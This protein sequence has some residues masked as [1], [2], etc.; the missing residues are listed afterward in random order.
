VTLENEQMAV[1]VLPDKGA[2]IYALR[3]KPQDIDVL[4]KAPWPVKMPGTGIPVASDSEAFWL[5]HYPGGWQE[6][7]PNV[8]DACTYRGVELGFHG[9]ASIL[10]WTYEVMERTL[11]RVAIRFSVDL[12]HSPFALTR[13]M[14]LTQ[15]EAVL[16]LSEEVVNKAP[17]DMDLMWGHHPAYGAPFLSEACVID[18]AADTM[19]ADGTYDPPGNYLAPGNV[20]RW[21]EGRDSQGR[22][23]DLSRIPGPHE[24]VSCFAYL[25]H[26]REGWIAITNTQLGFGVGMVWPKEIFPYVHLWQE[27][28]GSTVYPFYGRAYTVGIEPMSSIPGRGLAA[29]ME[30]TGT[31][32]RLRAGSRL[33]FEMRVVVFESHT[34]V[35]RIKPDGS[36]QVRQ[37]HTKMTEKENPNE[38]L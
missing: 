13:T 25:K 12:Y 29:T 38:S 23:K 35:Q 27:I 32:M 30:E 22:P 4:W 28:G 16:V 21:P 18:S 10:P 8:G 11:R 19:M 1:V 17:V 20:W 2:D 6:L 15:G 9:E 5:E 36:V 33:A 37:Q 3:Y 26:L 7:F 24:C 34:G 14:S 31:Q